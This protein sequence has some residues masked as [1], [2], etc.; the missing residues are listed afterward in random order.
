MNP[1]AVAG[2]SWL[3][4]SLFACIAE[5]SL[6]MPSFQPGILYQYRYSLDAQLG[7]VPR[8]SLQGSWMKAEALV[9]VQLLWRSQAGE[10]L[11]QV[12]IQNL[13]FSHEPE[14]EKNQNA[15]GG[16][17]TETTLGKENTAELQLPVFLHWN[18]GKVEGIYGDREEKPLIL[19]LKRGLISLLQFQPH[20]GRIT[21]EDISG[22]CK[23]VYTVSKDSVVKTKDLQECTRP[24]F[25]FTS[26]NK[27]FGVQLQPIS[28]SL[29]LMKGSVIQSVLSEESHVVS[30][31][32]RSSTGIMI[33]SRQQ[34]ELMSSSMPG[35]AEIHGQSLQEA[36]DSL[37]EKH[38]PISLV[39][40]PFKRMCTQCSSLKDYLKTVGN[41][42]VRMDI[43]KVSTTWQF[44][45]LIQML[46]SAKKRDVLQLLRKASEKTVPFFIDA[47]VA[48]QSTA[49]LVALSEFLDFSNKKQ[50]PLVEKFLYA[51]AFSPRPS[52]ELL[53]LLLDKLNGKQL[54][55]AIWKT[56][57][58]VTGSLVGKLCRMKLCGLQEVELGMETV[59]RRLSETEEESEMVTYL[60]SLKNAL[61]PETIPIL[62][63]YAEE[64]SA[65]VSG[66]A[67]SALQR[68]STQHIT[69]EVKKAM[70][71]IFHEKMRKYEKTC[72]LTAAEILL[73]NEPLP[74]DITNILLA[75]RELE[76][77]MAT[78]LLSKIQSSLHSPHHPARKAM[79]E[80]LKDPWIN[81]YSY[82]SKAG[83][84]SSFSGPLTVTK[85]VLFPF[86]LDLLFT[87]VGLLRK[88]VSD[89]LVLSH[90][91]QLQAAQ[92]TFEAKGLDS[93]LG[94]NTNEEEEQELMAGMSA[95]VFDVQ[96]RPVVFFQGYTD[97]M[98]K[99]LLSSGEPTNVIKGNVLLMDHQQAI[100]LQSGLQAVVELQGGLGIDIS[101]NIDVNIWEQESK[102]EIR[103]RGGLA[104]DFQA[105]LD[106][107][108]FQASLRRQTE[109]E[110]ALNFATALRFSGSPML[111]CLQLNEEQLPYREIFTISETSVNRS[112]TVRK[113]R[114]GMLAGRDFALHTANSEMC[115]ILLAEETEQ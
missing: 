3:I 23:V 88:S 77:E 21:E 11:L 25:G 12:Q 39:S 54:T 78:F 37:L 70:R 42:R 1:L 40:Q 35:L 15:T 34:L 107:P 20:A 49:S 72:R 76:T 93:V 68:F 69:G 99:V 58:I 44:H 43:S 94:E 50:E 32:L 61:L 41:R 48:A 82:L 27:I 97:L 98:A 96:L 100:P 52:K 7:Y 24:R 47:A 79:K 113:G 74:M 114:R 67:V 36:L 8:V 22:S 75:T 5:G 46:H 13:K 60:L 86:T 89:F 102:T 115:K 9:H 29:Y 106:A 92:V 80:L 6:Q 83:I 55:P 64:G 14:H 19:D 2:H 17:F 90:G 95:I 33:T 108:F 45:R 81:N 30:L 16:P 111:M 53:R 103:T 63:N 85:D 105:E 38:Q 109:V 87:E 101:A 28:R 65:A 59:L 4:F 66:T 26:V 31:T 62:L 84:S 10:Q 73:D 56:G 112:I 91:H 57:I 110:T 51:A 71:R 104:I 18:N